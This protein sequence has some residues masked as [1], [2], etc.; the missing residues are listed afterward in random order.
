MWKI[1]LMALL[2][3]IGNPITMQRFSVSSRI[4]YGLEL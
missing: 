1:S 2:G 4:N 3:S